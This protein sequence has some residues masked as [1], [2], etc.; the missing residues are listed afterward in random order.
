MYIA[1][2]V[3]NVCDIRSSYFVHVVLFLWP[4]IIA[5]H[6]TF[7]FTAIIIDHPSVSGR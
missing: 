2:I 1:N 5:V 3:Y 7:Q 6:Y 4:H